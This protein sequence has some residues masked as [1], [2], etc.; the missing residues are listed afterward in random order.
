LVKERN[1]PRQLTHL[2]ISRLA[3]EIVIRQ[4]MNPRRRSGLKNGTLTNEF[5]RIKP[6]KAAF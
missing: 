5:Q 6:E 3:Q 4:L 1:T 2:E